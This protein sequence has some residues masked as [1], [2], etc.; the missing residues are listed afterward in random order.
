MTWKELWEWLLNNM[1]NI[2]K[3]LFGLLVF[4]L[5]VVFEGHEPQSGIVVGVIGI[6]L[7]VLFS[8]KI[9]ELTLFNLLKVITEAEETTQKAKQ[10]IQELKDLAGVLSAPII[11]TLRFSSIKYGT[12]IS[13]LKITE[14]IKYRNNIIQFLKKIDCSQDIIKQELFE[15]DVRILKGIISDFEEYKKITCNQGTVNKFLF[16]ADSFLN[17][18]LFTEAENKAKELKIYDDE[19]KYLLE[20]VKNLSENKNFKDIDK[21]YKLAEK[22][23]Q[24]EAKRKEASKK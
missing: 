12:N 8:F 20:E 11:Q 18:I 7:I 2:L 24:E 23:E 22:L 13:G 21:L 6:T 3:T 4:G 15:L 17:E 1:T 19:F 9:K 14:H 10:T 5:V 16:Y